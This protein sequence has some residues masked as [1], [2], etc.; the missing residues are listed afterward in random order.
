MFLKL[1]CHVPFYRERHFKKTFLIVKLTAFFLLAACLQAG[2]SGYAQKITLSQN[3]VSLKKIFKEI[4][5]QSEYHFFYKDKLLKYAES[6]SVHVSNA[7]VEEVLDQCFKEQPLTYAILDKTIIVKAKK[8]H[9][10]TAPAPIE[11]ANTLPD[12]INGSVKDAQGSPLAGVS[13]VVKGNNTSKGTTTA[14]NGSFSIEA[15]VEDVLEF[16]MIGYQKRSVK[17]GQS[18]NLSIVMEIEVSVANEVVIVGFGTQKRKDLTG[19]VQSLSGKE[20]PNMPVTRASQLFSGLVSGVNFKQGSAQPGKDDAAITIRGLGTFSDAGTGPLVMI[21]GISSSFENVNPNDIASISV[22]KD[23]A[24]ASIYGARAANGVILIET[25]KGRSGGL[26]VN[27]NGYVGLQTPSEIPQL[28]DSWVYAEMINEALTNNGQSRQYTDEEIAKF[29]SGTD[30]NYPNKRHYDDL[31]KSGSGFQTNHYISLSGGNDKNQYMASFGYLDQEGL[32]DRAYSKRYD[33]RLNYNNKLTDKLNLNVQVSGISLTANEPT[34]AGTQGDGRRVE[35]L[36]SYAIKIPNTV[37]G[38][39]PDGTYGNFTGFTTEGWM[40]SHSFEKNTNQNFIGNTSLDWNI[41]KSLKVSGVAGYNFSLNSEDIY[42]A[43]LVVDR[44][45]TAGPANLTSIKT[46][47]SLLTLQALVNYDLSLAD[48]NIHFLGGYSE[49]GYSTNMLSGYRDDFPSNSLYQL[50]AGSRANMQSSGTASE[51]G[52]RSFFG[53]IN[54]NYKGKYLVEVNSRYDGSSRFPMGNKYGFFP[55]ASAGWRIS[56][57]EFFKNNVS[58]IENLKIR[59]SWGKLGNQ[60]IGNYPY[61]QVLSLGVDYP[62][63]GASETLYPGAAALILPNTNIHWEAT[64]IVDV[65]VDI[66]F[67]RQILSFSIDYFNKLTSGILYNISASSVLGLT[68]SVQNAGVVSNTGYDFNVRHQNTFGDF[69][70]SIAAN[71][72]YTKN[73][74]RE[75]ANVK[76]DIAKGLFVGN[77]L[78]SIYGYETEGL[79]IDQEDIDK[80][81]KQP[82]IVRPGDIKFKDISG[83]DGIPDGKVDAQYD[84]RIIGNRF[85]KYM[86]GGNVN[87]KYKNFDLSMQIQGVAGVNDI[88]TGYAGNAFN[89]GSNP[90]KWMIENRWTQDNPDPNAK[91]P[92]LNVLGGSEPQFDISTF[93]MRNASYLRINNLQLGYSVPRSVNDRFKIDN[94]RFY[95][96]ARNLYNFDRYYEGWDPEIITH[97]PPVRTYVLGI[98]LNL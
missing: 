56:E 8:F 29:K 84:R 59:G 97:Y 62:F 67:P 37:P 15:N 9:S 88:I 98:T 14:A 48:H 54:Y 66:A 12:I 28:V 83:P 4:E 58:W 72:A 75:L 20:I 40:D 39:L 79:F 64:R 44:S 36:I 50:N 78:Q 80:S 89:R 22:L 73:E 74:V 91:Y 68:P 76:Q 18:N 63:G 32:V 43:L 94:L 61:Q 71:F 1:I 17:V 26:K 33:I 49:E 13:V 25:K 23:A 19:A 21:D 16:T 55:S 2:A 24:S 60:N 57:E 52:L 77:S 11:L 6:V 86:Y 10:M 34:S 82:Y 95:I 81:P 38:R 51:W 90:Q 96:G 92:R 3:N 35:G 31:I 65:G 69:S 7:S 5:R 70:Y 27:Y 53:R 47:S 46:T 87:V 45:F 41:T 93:I 85:P 30:P 42:R